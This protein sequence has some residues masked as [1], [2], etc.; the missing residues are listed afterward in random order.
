LD[1]PERASTVRNPDVGHG[2]PARRYLTP[3]LLCT[4]NV[5]P[6]HAAAEP[7]ITPIGM[8]DRVIII[9]HRH[10]WSSGAEC[11]LLHDRHVWS[12]SSQ[13]CRSVVESS[14]LQPL[15]A[16]LA[17]CTHLHRTLDLSVKCFQSILPHDGPDVSLG[18]H[19]VS[20]L[21]GSGLGYETVQK[22]VSGRLRDEE[23]FRAY[24]ALSVVDESS[25]HR[26]GRCSL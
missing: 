4:T 2:N 15:P 17:L 14:P 5:S 24:A 22:P 10:H 25:S 19:R 3:N 6:P 16:P 8:P 26:A 21:E 13:D 18:T 23:P 9:L 7:E 1:P 20:N 12:Y 11:F